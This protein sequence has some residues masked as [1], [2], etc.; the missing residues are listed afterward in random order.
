[1]AHQGKAQ[2]VTELIKIID[3]KA[4]SGFAGNPRTSR[5]EVSSGGWPLKRARIT[6]THPAGLFMDFSANRHN[7]TALVAFAQECIRDLENENS[8]EDWSI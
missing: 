1:V 7:A 2:V 3:R 8:T 5:L 6:I 4:A